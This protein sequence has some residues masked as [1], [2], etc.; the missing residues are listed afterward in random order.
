MTPRAGYHHG[1]LRNALEQAALQLVAERGP[2][3]FSLA[4]AS[5]RA[6]V[7]AAAP[8]RHFANKEALLAA[9]A[10]RSYQEQ[11]ERF[12][13]AMTGVADPAEQLARFA[14]AYVEFAVDQQALFDV[15]FGA[16]LVKADHPGLEEAGQQ[17]LDVL[18]EPAERLRTTPDASVDLIHTIAATAHG[19]AAFLREGVLTD[20]VRTGLRAAEA[21]RVLAQHAGERLPG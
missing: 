20:R 4:E 8:F 5:R 10:L 9:L 11:R 13:A 7:S 1:D 14:T 18:R 12:A 2:Q 16:G 19:F 15:T 6:G 17:V 21:A 3:G